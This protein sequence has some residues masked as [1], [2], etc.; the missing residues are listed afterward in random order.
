MCRIGNWVAATTEFLWFLLLFL[1]HFLRAT[2]K[3]K[4]TRK[5]TKNKWKSTE[6]YQIN[7]SILK[8]LIWYA[9]CFA[10]VIISIVFR[11]SF[12]FL[13]LFF[14][15][16]LRRTLRFNRVR[17]FFLFYVC[18]ALVV[19]YSM[20][21]HWVATVI[22]HDMVNLVLLFSSHTKK[23]YT[24]LN[25][26]GWPLTSNGGINAKKIKLKLISLQIRR[27][28]IK[29][30][31]GIWNDWEKNLVSPMINWMCS[32]DD[33]AAYLWDMPDFVLQL[34]TP[35]HFIVKISCIE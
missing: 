24:L 18:D 31:C 12:Y 34:Q 13:V 5:K 19:A 15:L 27:C 9:S 29:R 26:G 4:N 22:L 17:Y 7:I 1:I 16:L 14:F 32:F 2:P 33:E 8:E 21:F 6:E 11:F 30:G 25:A 23:K 35:N 3:R 10:L 28:V 20:A